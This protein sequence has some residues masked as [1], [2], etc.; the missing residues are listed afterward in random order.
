MIDEI[1]ARQRTPA[2]ISEVPAPKLGRMP[3]LPTNGHP[4]PR[5]VADPSDIRLERQVES[6]RGR[7]GGSRAP[8]LRE[9]APRRGSACG[10]CPRARARA[11]STC[12]RTRTAR[13]GR[14][15]SAGRRGSSASSR[16]SASAG[17]EHAGVPGGVR[18]HVVVHCG[19]H[20]APVALAGRDRRPVHDPGQ[21]EEREQR[22]HQRGARVVGGDR[23][24]QVRPPAAHAAAARPAARRP[25]PAPGSRSPRAGS[26]AARRPGPDPYGGSSS[27]STPS[28]T[29]STRNAGH[30][31]APR[32]RQRRRPG[33]RRSTCWVASS[34]E[35]GAGHGPDRS[36]SGRYP[37]PQ[38][39]SDSQRRSRASVHSGRGGDPGA[40]RPPRGRHPPHGDRDRA[41]RRTGR[42]YPAPD[43]GRP[44]R[45]DARDA[46]DARHRAARD[47]ALP[48][49]QG[50]RL[51][52]RR[53][54]AGS[55]LGRSGLGDARPR[56]AVH[57]APRPRRARHPRRPARAHLRPVHGPRRRHHARPRRQRAL[58]RP[59]ARLRRDG[60][61]AARHDADRHRAGDGVQA[62]RR[63]ALRDHLVRR[64]LDVARR[65]PRG[66]ELGRRAEAAGRLRPREQPVRVLDAARPAVRGRPRRARGRLRLPGPQ[67]RRQRPRGDVRGRPPG[68]RA[69][70]GAARARR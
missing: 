65:L 57:P 53:L 17:R 67:G 70:G 41:G 50:P 36:G 40:P 60:L 61:D 33:Q 56:P 39:Q 51:V 20:R 58:R 26:P 32:R 27:S 38:R 15:R 68:A 34:S 54:R 8:R 3:R 66:D 13:A 29:V 52:L 25:R 5:P 30:C 28:T 9:P 55:R 44:G 19:E 23:A 43:P 24:R 16:R 21:H 10:R 2:T 7:E 69:R 18:A 6:A 12:P 11:R 37:C 4:D 14:H 62:A 35:R 31:H 63:E 47:D 45:A 46:H 1:T 48:P 64:R 22:A 59:H 42:R 49:G